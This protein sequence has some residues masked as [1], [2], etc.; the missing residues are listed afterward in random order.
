MSPLIWIVP[1]IMSGLFS[2]DGWHG[3]HFLGRWSNSDTPCPKLEFH[4]HGRAMRTMEGIHSL[5]YRAT[6]IG[7]SPSL[8]CVGP[9]GAGL[10][11]SIQSISR[12]GP[13]GATQI[14][15]Q[16]HD[17]QVAPLTRNSLM[18]KQMSHARRPQPI[19]PTASDSSDYHQL[20]FRE[21]SLGIWSS[22]A[23]QRGLECVLDKARAKRVE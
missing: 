20:D 22:S 3:R 23:A 16:T 6:L 9:N 21:S 5:L 13:V 12:T 10:V 19:M 18:Q 11:S 14:E 15:A 4:E 7:K 2:V 1:A 8:A 17:E